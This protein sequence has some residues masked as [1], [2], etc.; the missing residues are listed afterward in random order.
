MKMGTTLIDVIGSTTHF[1]SQLEAALK[2]KAGTEVVLLSANSGAIKTNLRIP[3]LLLRIIT[4]VLL[5]KNYIVLFA[6]AIICSRNQLFIFNIPLVPSIE[7]LFV[8]LIGLRSGISVG[9][10]HNEIPS[11]GETNRIRNYRYAEFYNCCDVIV[12][13]DSSILKTFDDTFP[14]AFPVLLDLPSYKVPNAN[15]Y[16]YRED[17]APDIIKLAVLGT[18]RPYKNLEVIFP[19]FEM[20]DQRQRK[21]L[22]L[23][24]SGKAFYDIRNTVSDLEGLCLGEFFYNDEFLGDEQFYREMAD[25]D[26]LL[27]PHSSSSG[28]ALLSVAASL[29]I[30]IIGSKLP[31]VTDFVDRYRSGVIFDHLSRGDLFRLVSNLIDDRLAIK[32]LKE[33][34]MSAVD[35]VPN[36]DDYVDAIILVCEELTARRSND[37]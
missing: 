12:F 25:C 20:L 5:A 26:F 15:D 2:D 18:I 8:W 1:T 6:R 37:N 29:G 35:S 9:I 23:R 33:N 3:K 19:E 10:L 31:V 4:L 13:H 16:K 28:S 32:D 30:P 27:L 34:A 11:H 14:N 21:S 7:I 24:I 22:S 36:W 17:L